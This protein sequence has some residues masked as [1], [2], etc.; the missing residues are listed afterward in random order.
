M[1]EKAVQY[2]GVPFDAIVATDEL[3]A[4]YGRTRNSTP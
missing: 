2:C 3:T 1:V 4:G